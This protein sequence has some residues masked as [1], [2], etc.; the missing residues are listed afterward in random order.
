MNRREFITAALAVGITQTK[1]AEIYRRC[2]I[3]KSNSEDE[4]YK[5]LW[6]AYFTNAVI[7]TYDFTALNISSMVSSI[8]NGQQLRGVRARCL[9]IPFMPIQSYFAGSSTYL[10]EVTCTSLPN[11]SYI[12]EGSN[13]LKDIYLTTESKS[14]LKRSSAIY[15]TPPKSKWIEGVTFHCTDGTLKWN[16]DTEVWDET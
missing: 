2:L 9:K 6:E 3:K 1:A 8:A 13:N 14:Q 5:E 16:A 10:E 12:F 15:Y 4:M 7:D 11:N